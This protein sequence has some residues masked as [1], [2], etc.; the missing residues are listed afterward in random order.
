MKIKWWYRILG[1]ITAV[2]ISIPLQV[3][4]RSANDNLKYPLD[5]VTM[6]WI[7]L[8]LTVGLVWAA[9]GLGIIFDSVERTRELLEK[10]AHI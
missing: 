4:L 1:M 3:I 6:W 7:G 5:A 2:T 8:L 10:H 9:F